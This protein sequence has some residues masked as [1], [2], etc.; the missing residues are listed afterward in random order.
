MKKKKQ[1]F[2]VNYLELTPFQNH[3]FEVNKNGLVNVFVPKFKNKMLI[4]FLIPKMKSP[5]IKIKLDEFGSEVWQLIDGSKKVLEI[6]EKLLEKFGDRIQPVNE[7]LTKFL[8]QLYHYKFINFKEIKIS[9][10]K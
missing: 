8:T 6:S 2:E 7:R 10:E 5:F 1:Q 3:D 9:K 4:K